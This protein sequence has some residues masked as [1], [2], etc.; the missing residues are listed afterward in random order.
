[1]STINKFNIFPRIY[2]A[3]SAKVAVL[4]NSFAMHF[5]NYSGLKI[6]RALY[7]LPFFI[8][9]APTTEPVKVRVI[10]HVNVTKTQRNHNG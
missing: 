8:F 9:S 2:V 6:H 5:D 1:M 7:E 10:N 4:L 3:V